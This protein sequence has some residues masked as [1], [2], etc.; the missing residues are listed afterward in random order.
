MPA[1]CIPP[2]SRFG[3]GGERGNPRSCGGDTKINVHSPWRHVR[4][5]RVAWNK[6][7]WTKARKMGVDFS[8]ERRR[9]EQAFRAF[10]TES[11]GSLGT[12]GSPDW[13]ETVHTSNVSTVYAG[14]FHLPP[15][16]PTGYLTWWSRSKARLSCALCPKR[17]SLCQRHRQG[18]HARKT[19]CEEPRRLL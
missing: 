1:R 9:T 3:G 12:T 16:H 15:L 13:G 18:S 4:V 11:L 8:P 2:C 17:A 6:L 7:K 19:H 14:N 5:D 10:C